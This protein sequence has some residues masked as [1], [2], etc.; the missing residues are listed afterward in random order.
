MQTRLSLT[1]VTVAG[2]ALSGCFGSDDSSE[3]QSDSFVSATAAVTSQ[4]EASS[5][6][7]EATPATV[8][9]VMATSPETGEAMPL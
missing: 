9:Q 2:L 7:V 3:N 1:L 8:E 4:P 6:L 5:E